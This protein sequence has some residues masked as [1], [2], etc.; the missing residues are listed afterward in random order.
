[1]IRCVYV[2]II[3]CVKLIIY[4]STPYQERKNPAT[5][6]RGRIQG[7]DKEEKEPV[8]SSRASQE[9]SGEGERPILHNRVRDATKGSCRANRNAHI[10]DINKC[11][12]ILINYNRILFLLLWKYLCIFYTY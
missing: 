11:T 1:M 2:K 12:I 9:E 5:I 3:T 8:T 4:V 6:V 7:K 10:Y